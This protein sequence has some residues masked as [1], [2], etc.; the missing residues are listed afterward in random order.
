MPGL[1][2]LKKFNSDILAL[3]NEV[4]ERASRGEK[5]IL[6][7]FSKT[8]RDVDDSEDF[9]LGMPE[10]PEQTVPSQA[11]SDAED[12]SDIT[13]TGKNDAAS[14]ENGETSSAAVPDLS[15]LLNPVIPS[16]SAGE[17][18]MP[19]LSEFADEA[20]Q[21]IEEAEPEE[22]SIADMNLDDLLGDMSGVEAEAS[23]VLPEEA[24]SD[25][26]SDEGGEPPRTS[27]SNR[28]GG[29]S[30]TS[31]VLSDAFSL[32]SDDAFS[33]AVS[34]I[35]AHTDHAHT[36][37][38]LPSLDAFTL[39]PENDF[40]VPAPLVDEAPSERQ[41]RSEHEA[42]SGHQTLSEHVLPSEDAGH[43]DTSSL[44][45]PS[46][47]QR[48]ADQKTDEAPPPAVESSASDW[49]DDFDTGGQAI[50]MNIEIPGDMPEGEI[51][52][53]VQ[54]AGKTALPE[55][56][57]D[58]VSAFGK[59]P[60]E[61]KIVR[62]SGADETS[63][64]AGT[65]R[66]QSSASGTTVN[67]E[68]LS[69]LDGTPDSLELPDFDFSSMFNDDGL[70]PAADL[71]EE[72]K[73]SSGF[74]EAAPDTAFGP[75]EISLSGEGNEIAEKPLRQTTDEISLR[76]EGAENEGTM[77]RSGAL[78]SSDEI[79]L[80]GD[81]AEP[82]EETPSDMLAAR[83]PQETFDPD[84]FDFDLDMGDGETDDG[85]T[86]ARGETGAIGSDE[87]SGDTTSE[88]ADDEEKVPIEHFDT[89][90]MEGL[91]FTVKEPEK[92][93]AD[94]TDFEL[95]MHGDLGDFEIP[96][97]SD[98]T[99]VKTDKSGRIKLPTPD[100]RGAT[101]GEKPP[102]NTLT[103]AQY[104]KFL[105]NLALYPLNVRLA[106]ENLLVANEFT[107]DAQFEI[108]EKILNKAPA[109]Q[110]AST[111]EKMLDIAIPV[112]RDFERRTVAEYNAYKASFQYQLQ[113]RIVPG[114][115]LALL[116]A[117]AVFGLIIFTRNFIW[118]PLR[119]NGLYKQG[120]ALIKAD[121]Y[122]QSE[123]LF[124][125]A[126]GV[127]LQ[128]KWLFKYARAYRERKQY[129]RAERMYRNILYY[130]N[131]DKEAGIEYARMECD[132]LANYEKAE[133][134]ARRSVLDY[135][136]ND[137]DGILL[138][139]DI[140]LEWATEKDPSK[141][142][143]A[144]KQYASLVQLYGPTDQYLARMMRYFVR[145][146]NLREVLQLKDRFYPK[147][148]SLDA[149]DWT[150]MSGYLLDKLYGPLPPKDEYLRTKIEDVRDMLD[151]AVNADRS[152][153]VAFYNLS[154]YFVQMH[155]SER[156][157]RMLEHTVKLFEEKSQNLRRRDIYKQIDSY[158]LLGEQYVLGKEYLTAEEKYTDGISLYE[159]EKANSGF[160]GNEAIGKLYADSGDIDYFIRGDYEGAYN[161][162]LS[163][164]RTHYDTASLHYRV[165]FIQYSKNDLDGAVGSFIK[166]GAEKPDDDHLLL[167]MGNTL[168]L[169]DSDYAAEGYYTQLVRNLDDEFAKKGLAFTQTKAA[170]DALTEL[171][172][173]AANNLGVTLF[174]L[175]RRTGNSRMNAD[176]M[177]QLS[178][179][180]RAWDALTRNEATMV[181]LPGGNLAE[182]NMRY[183]SRPMPDYEPAI[184]TDIPKIL[185]GEKELTQ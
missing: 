54:S 34:D 1:S 176:A 81:A 137:A 95:G 91:D 73:T 114:I 163:A 86:T 170:E 105:A 44:A 131:Y 100:F 41:V 99:E 172:L 174:R 158:R 156:A 12:F 70:S 169:R 57:A 134:I 179:S 28:N 155:D 43:L 126:A 128:K 94:K 143:E 180:M 157:L 106:V 46:P 161:D 6:I 76:D 112:P 182:Q 39:S 52:S 26:P 145:T 17:A 111:L 117:A 77:Q 31:A 21:K 74:Y 97:F 132:D 98:T 168:S 18:E 171:Y 32:P 10:V 130:F 160:A 50:D 9:V 125:E 153:P 175:A 148:K 82:S 184:Y 64:D 20:E 124:N 118:R 35:P 67:G 133:E 4:H 88:N 19:D 80:G 68:P 165:G 5:P 154:R 75:D 7:P 66:T 15:D 96:G 142:E 140:F 108:V 27:A 113:N 178:V 147:A 83:L 84:T 89:S 162:Y 85:G 149:D 37:P 2:Q 103:D 47:T 139:G 59:A 16:A 62:A 13:G 33:S 159:R 123:A 65:D 181:R 3:G 56:D 146:D 79:S 45:A 90:E 150:E 135:H 101:E 166:A 40:S 78:S 122:P 51:E 164:I 42:P 167:A 25:V 138:L 115:V 104:K 151:R 107:D 121:E 71:S 129:L 14:K 55:K 185:T 127:Q 63:S 152:N 53:A 48:S 102:K 38:D 58:R 8:I 30:R 136:I 61:Q 69:P 72:K 22:V 144:R 36:V 173:K 116:S 110:V 120:Y 87:K 29:P 119:A 177:V 49:A 24:A 23:D 109:R 60:E 141:F 92:S 93:E 183:M 11:S